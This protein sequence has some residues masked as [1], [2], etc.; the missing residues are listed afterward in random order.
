MKALLLTPWFVVSA[1][2]H[3]VFS[4]KFVQ[5]IY[6]DVWGFNYQGDLNLLRQRVNFYTKDMFDFYWYKRRGSVGKHYEF[7]LEFNLELN[8]RI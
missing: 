6:Y 7:N 2:C 4:W 3:E 1:E 8:L 5:I